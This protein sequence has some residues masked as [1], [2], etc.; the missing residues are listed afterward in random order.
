MLLWRSGL[1]AD[2]SSSM[3]HA[4]GPLAGVRII[5][6]TGIGPVPHAAMLLADMGAT[7]IR[8]DRPGGYPALG[9]GLDFASMS[10][11]A[12]FYRGR[13][14]V[15]V[16]LKTARGRDLVLRLIARADALIEGFRPGAMERLGLG[17]DPAHATNSA[18]VYARVTGWGQDGPMAGMAGHD[19][20][21]LAL[22]GALSLFGRD[23]LPPVG[24]PPLLGDMASG[25]LMAVIGLLAGVMQARATGRGQVV[26]ASIVHGSAS[27]STLIMSLAAMDLHGPAGT[28]PLDGGRH[29]YR[30]YICADGKCIAVGAIEPAFRRI[31]LDRLGLADDPRMR[32][33]D[34]Y[35][36]RKLTDLFATQPR[37]HWAA[38]FDGTDGCVTPRAGHERGA[39]SFGQPRR[40]YPNRRRCPAKA[41]A[42]LA[43]AGRI[44]FPV[45][46]GCCRS[47]PR[48]VGELGSE[49]HRDRGSGFGGDCFAVSLDN[50]CQAEGK[51]LGQVGFANMRRLVQVGDGSDD[52]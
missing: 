7:V 31:L 33:D 39:G 10:S 48:G 25:A 24:L 8:I 16:D 4:I 41:R 32:D 52:P 30:T 35:A 18:L 3:G 46:K 51:R 9:E 6:M 50:R 12:I 27:L 49:R 21:Y 1:S 14:M 45:A 5:E 36:T 47:V 37:D 34:N 19:L 2:T 43:G 17:P 28:N 11:A 40:L 44:H 38:L 42:A 29:Y 23:G 15:E 26:D 22:S 13:P 20:N